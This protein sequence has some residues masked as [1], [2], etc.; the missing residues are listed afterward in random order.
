[1]SRLDLEPTWDEIS[2]RAYELFGDRYGELSWNRMCEGSFE[3]EITD[4]EHAVEQELIREKRL[5]AATEDA[6]VSV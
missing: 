3:T 4:M 1:M 5:Q 6:I 2:E